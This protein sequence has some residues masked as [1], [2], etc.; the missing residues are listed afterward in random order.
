MERL[1]W[2]D[3]QMG[4]K[5]EEEQQ[6]VCTPLFLISSPYHAVFFISDLS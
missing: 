1:G 3:I 6:H 4:T 2:L 5:E